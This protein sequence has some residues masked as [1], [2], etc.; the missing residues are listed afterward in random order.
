MHSNNNFEQYK[1]IFQDKYN[2]CLENAEGGANP[3]FELESLLCYLQIGSG[4][5]Q[6]R[7]KAV[8]QLERELIHHF[9][10]KYDFNLSHE[11]FYEIIS[12]K[13]RLDIL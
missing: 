12:G 9:A 3:S 11:P 2:E 5:N 13:L 4:T 1:Q 8:C 7:V 10:T 6:Q